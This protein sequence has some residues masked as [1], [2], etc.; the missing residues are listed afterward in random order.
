MVGIS[1]S[2]TNAKVIRTAARLAQALHGKFTAL[3]VQKVKTNDRNEANSERLQQHIKL[4]EQL[5]G[6]IV[7]VQ[8]DDVAAALANY[9]Q[10]SGV[11]KLV[12][13][14]TAMKKKWWLPNSKISDRFNDFIPNLAIHIVPDEDN[15]PMRFP[16]I[17]PQL[18]FE[19]MDLL[20]MAIVFGL[21]SFIGLFFLAIGVS[22]SN[23]ITIY[24]LG[25][26]VLATWTSGW[27]VSIISSLGAVLIFNFFFTEPRFSFEAY[28][29]DY[30][31]TFLI[32]FLSGFITSSL[33]RKVKEQAVVAVRKSYRMEVLLETNRKLQHAKSIEEI[34]N[35][36]MSQIV[37]LVEKPVEFF[38]IDNKLIVKSVF[39]EQIV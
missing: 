12:I 27:M 9:A 26:L 5:G 11:T 4:T 19:W 29:R 20:K 30:P 8:E 35:E 14:R 13:G 38:E 33:T 16:E 6:H 10:I 39:F 36:G 25:V 3:Y 2:P 31:M 7:I 23:I 21:A 28:H 32:M 17:K 15:E 22:E 24:I 18:K 1:S 37:K 34:I